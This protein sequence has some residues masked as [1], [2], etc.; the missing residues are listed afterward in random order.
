VFPIPSPLLTG[1]TVVTVDS[2][3]RV[4]VEGAV[5][6]GVTTRVSAETTRGR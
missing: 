5:A 1:G 6:I 4:L 2:H 3:R